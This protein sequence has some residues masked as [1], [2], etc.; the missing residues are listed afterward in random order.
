[1]SIF[2]IGMLL[3]AVLL[4]GIWAHNFGV[5]I[6]KPKIQ[7]SNELSPLS[8]LKESAVEGFKSVKESAPK[9]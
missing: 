8:V 6:A 2:Y 5:N 3:S 1:M 9:W 4:L 7:K